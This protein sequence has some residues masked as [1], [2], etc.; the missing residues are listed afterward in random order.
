MR[1]IC[2]LCM[3]DVCACMQVFSSVVELVCFYANNAIHLTIDKD[4]GAVLGKVQLTA[5]PTR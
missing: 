4:S 5:S 1:E 3:T 2:A